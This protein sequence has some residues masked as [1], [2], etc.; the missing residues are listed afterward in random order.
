M[1]VW[2]GLVSGP[3]QDLWMLVGTTDSHMKRRN[4]HRSRMLGFLG[5]YVFLLAL[6]VWCVRPACES[7]SATQSS[8]YRPQKPN[9]YTPSFRFHA[10]KRLFCSHPESGCHLDRGSGWDGVVSGALYT[11]SEASILAQRMPHFS[12]MGTTHPHLRPGI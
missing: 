1:R 7:F 5:G 2:C 12:Q 8:Y 4:T 10:C 6:C 3:H 9:T 11:S